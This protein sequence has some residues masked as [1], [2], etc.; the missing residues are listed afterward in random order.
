M[1]NENMILNKKQ[2]LELINN[3]LI[4]QRMSIK[5]NEGTLYINKNIILKFNYRAPSKEFYKFNLKE[6]KKW[7]LDGKN[8]YKLIALP[9][10]KNSF[11]Y[12]LIKIF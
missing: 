12:D 10:G 9:S 6:V 7:V 1:Y 2:V 8:K 5:N 3:L 4:G 11:S